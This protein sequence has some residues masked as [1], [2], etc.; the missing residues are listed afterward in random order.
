MLLF[1]IVDWQARLHLKRQFIKLRDPKE[2]RIKMPGS[3]QP[4][5][6]LLGLAVKGHF[7]IPGITCFHLSQSQAMLPLTKL[8]AA[9]QKGSPP[10][11]TGSLNPVTSDH[12]VMM[13]VEAVNHI[14][15][16]ESEKVV[17][18]AF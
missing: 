17:H 10:V 6:L 7:A 16:G 8:E 13:G 3:G 18:A 9:I 4:R 5:P 15:Q 14:L 2:E 11:E 1:L 12:S